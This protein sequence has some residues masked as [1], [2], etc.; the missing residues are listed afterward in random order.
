MKYKIPER[1]T[2]KF[3]KYD[4]VPIGIYKQGGAINLERGKIN[5]AATIETKLKIIE[6]YEKTKKLQ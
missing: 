6:E 5:K 1:W 4:V 3:H 2:G